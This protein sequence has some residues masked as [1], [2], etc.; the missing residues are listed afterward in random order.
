[1]KDLRLGEAAMLAGVI[2]SPMRWSPVNHP[3]KAKERQRYV[4]RRMAEEGFI[5]KAQA[6]AEA[7]RPVATHPP[8]RRPPGA[9]YAD[10][11]RRVLDERYGAE[12]VE[13]DGLRVD[14]A[15]DPTLQRYA[16]L[17]LEADLRAVDK[18]QGWRGPILHLEPGQRAAALPAWRE[19]LQAAQEDARPGEV[20]VWDLSGV[21][22]DDIEPGEEPSHDV[23][24][25]AQPRALEAGEL[26]AGLV[27]KVEEK[28]A[29]IDL[30][31]ARGVVP[32][33]DVAWARKWNP[34][35]ATAAP[36]RMA[37]VLAEGDVVL[38][39][40]MTG[41][42]APERAARDGKPVVL[43]LEQ[44]PRVEGAL[45]ALDPATRGV[46]ALVGGYDF[47]RSQFNR[48]LQAKRQ[49]GSAFKPFVWGAAIESRQFTPATVVYDTPDLY[50]DPWT[51]KEWKPRNFEK[52]VF[53]GAM[54][55]R[56]A[57][58]E[59]KNTVSVKLVDALGVDRVVGF[60]RRMGISS[61]LPRNLTLALGTGEVTPVE[62]VNAYATIA[63]EGAPGTP[64]LV[65]RV[66]DRDGAVLQEDAP[67]AAATGSA[68]GA[69]AIPPAPAVATPI[70]ASTTAAAPPSDPGPTPTP[71][72]GDA[73]AGGTPAPAEFT[74]PEAG[75]RPD[76]AFVL[77]AMM[78][79]VI[80]SGTGV[81]A[82][83]LGR[84][85]AGKTGTAQE[86][87]DAWFVGFTPDLV[88]G[89]WVGFDD[90]S[91]LGPRE[92][93]AGA[94][95]PGWLSFMKAAVG[96]RAAAEFRAP[97]NVE[98]ARI[99]PATGLLAPEKR[100][101]APVVP[102]LAGTAPTRRADEGHDASPQNFFM[103]DR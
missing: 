89:A 32:L 53:E 72:P 64:R 14:V 4:L 76:V 54:L 51:G 23:R 55:L 102:F 46:R 61:D 74:I 26:Y 48:A 90:H 39:R 77:E 60:A 69:A 22:P 5:T 88:A 70:P 98:Y 62:L 78:R 33:A 67:A 19:R 9:W 10:A 17:A 28:A 12:R 100:A 84:P 68:D 57:L 49:P 44:V 86:H 59:S 1:V 73:A 81:A 66:R 65:L 97:P 91:P 25:M 15:M 52:D 7:A 93:G 80:E 27:S 42:V 99:D 18:R 37:S 87:R 71:P 63:A 24:R 79:V 38:V 41:K 103:D 21:N 92:T 20:I 29:T 75:T 3:V 8:E 85:A 43:S 83:D 58:A 50:R 36:K 13:T 6:D 47:R 40:V 101:D 35:T 34:T 30:G 2:Q 16:E 95:L 45:V 56:T 31:G 96:G 82:K 11:V 94:A